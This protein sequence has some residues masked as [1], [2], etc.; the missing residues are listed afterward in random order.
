MQKK[1]YINADKATKEVLQDMLK[2]G[3]SK[4]DICKRLNITHTTLKK[5]LYKFDLE[6]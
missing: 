6:K 5:R 2:A 1:E 3:M 4:S